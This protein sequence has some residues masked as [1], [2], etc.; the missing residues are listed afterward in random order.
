MRYT[1]I[2]ATV[3]LLTACAGSTPHRMPGDAKPREPFH[4][5]VEMILK[6]DANKDGSVTLAELDAGLRAEFSAADTNH[7]GVLEIDEM[8]AVNAS[9][10][11]DEGTAASPLIDWNEDGHVDFREF[12]GSARAIFDE[13]D[14]DGDG[15][16]TPDEL[17]P[18]HRE[19]HEPP[20]M[21]APYS[22]Q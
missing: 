4:P 19:H 11:H 21:I 5:P 9:R 17:H 18:H 16:L 10:L 22:Q 7:D 13:L 8:R 15:V 3:L 14:T 1:P 20:P 12:S 6:Y 2:F